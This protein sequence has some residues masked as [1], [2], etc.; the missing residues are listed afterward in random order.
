[1]DALIIFLAIGGELVDSSLGMMYGTILSPLLI[2]MGYDATLVVPS[3]LLSQGMGGLVA[4]LRHHNLGNS[5]FGGWTRDFKIALSVII[6]GVICVF[7]GVY[8]A[9]NISKFALNMYIGVLVLIMGLLCV[10][11]ANYTFSWPKIIG[12]GA[13]SGFNKAMSGGGFGPLT[14]TGKILSGVD[15][16]VSVATTTYA[17][18]PICFLAF[19]LWVI[20]SG[21]IDWKFPLLL[22]LG[23]VIG[24]FLGPYI[25]QRMR[26]VRLRY[27]A[28][29]L[30]MVCGA[31][32]IAKLL[33]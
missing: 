9:V 4:T 23:S 32:I 30:A 31:W 8:L 10:R 11:P 27:A 22:T 14:S 17:E 13:L 7:L 1:L 25:T 16:K 28:G 15:P 2:G 5:N 6:P 29:I 21:A 3:I 18:V 26:T 33:I 12:I 19:G 24:G 20:M